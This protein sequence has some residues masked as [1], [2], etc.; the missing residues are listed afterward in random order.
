MIYVVLVNWRGYHD[1]IECLESL[2]R[3][4]APALK[5]IVVDNESR[6]SGVD[7]IKQWA[8]GK[9]S[10][11][12]AGSPWHLLP[13]ERRRKPSVAIMSPE[14]DFDMKSSALVT[15]VQVSFNS[16][17]AAANNIGARFALSDPACDYVW[18]LNNDTVV[19]ENGLAA[20]VTCVS[21]DP[22]IGVCGSTLVYYD[23]PTVVQSIGG[24]FNRFF[25]R[26]RN[27]HIGKPVTDLPSEASVTAQLD[28]VIGASMFV[29][30]GYMSKIGFMEEKY[31]LYFEELDWCR[32]NRGQFRIAW[33]KD[34]IIYHKE[35]RSLG[36]NTRGR[37][38]DTALYY[39]NVNF[40]RFTR[41]FS[42][43]LLPLAIVK[44]CLVSAWFLV[45]QDWRGAAAVRGAIGDFLV[46]RRRTGPIML[47]V[48]Q[49]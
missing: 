37:S 23:E 2:T 46:G 35:G 27:L 15:V 33:A 12:T 30:R 8:D 47:S 32:R 13:A 26:G 6:S 4:R 16:G 19:D 43:L 20:L 14:D 7:E 49:S 17:Y 3:I 36:T 39:Y 48:Q 34:S 31:F 22:Q 24:R 38:S 18:F 10:T 41:H 28:Y 40:L 25:G 5:I 1:T 11:A 29:S 9:L 21:K 42:P 44:V 45:R